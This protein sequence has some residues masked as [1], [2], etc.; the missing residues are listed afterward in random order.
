[1]SVSGPVS[2]SIGATGQL[3]LGFSGLA[4]G[5]RYTGAVAYSGVAG[6]SSTLLKVNTP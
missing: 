3:S 1:M 6:M 4:S 5:T 2:A